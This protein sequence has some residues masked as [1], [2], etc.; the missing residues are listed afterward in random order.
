MKKMRKF[1]EYV[2]KQ[3]RELAPKR[4]W[5][6]S[7]LAVGPEYQ[8]SGYGSQLIRGMLP[9]MDEEGLSCYVETEGEQNVAIY[10]HFGFQVIEEFE[11]PDSKDKL[12]AMLREPKNLIDNVPLGE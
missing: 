7:V 10:E 11:I 8:G 3:H 4:H 12:A 9:R 6:L 2:E 5:Y 1:D